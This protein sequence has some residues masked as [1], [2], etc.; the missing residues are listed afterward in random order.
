MPHKLVP[1]SG[2]GVATWPGN[3]PPEQL[4]GLRI[5]TDKFLHRGVL[6][7]DFAVVLKREFAKVEEG[8]LVAVVRE[9]T[10]QLEEYWL[11]LDDPLILGRIIRSWRD[12]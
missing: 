5:L 3:Y 7:G 12:Y 1:L 10:V 6:P 11:G 4:I 2:F 8:D 9:Q